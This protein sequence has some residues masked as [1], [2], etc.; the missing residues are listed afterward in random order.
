MIPDLL[1]KFKNLNSINIW[2]AAASSGQEIY[3]IA[4]ELEN[5]RKNNPAIPEPI[6]LASDISD[7]ILRRA[8]EGIYS[9]LE[10][11]RG[12]P[13]SHLQEYFDQVENN[14][15]R[16]KEFLRRNLT[17]KKLNLL[18][19]WGS[20]GPFE[21]IYCRNVLIYQSVENKK[22]VL[23]A[24]LEVLRPGGYLILGAAES[25]FGLSNAFEQVGDEKTIVY[26]KK[27]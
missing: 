12:L 5:L 15:W 3:T 14:H 1:K 11:Q 19:P 16:V 17:F 8:K 20:L 10:V 21:I 18:E 13:A 4:M 22:K 6:L 26:V 23:E 9:Q 27:A 24:I 7:T 2:S 25:L